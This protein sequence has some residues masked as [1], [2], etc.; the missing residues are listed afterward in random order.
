MLNMATVISPPF[1]RPPPG[2]AILRRGTPPRRPNRASS[3]PSRPCWLSSLTPRR[4]RRPAGTTSTCSSVQLRQGV[5][6]A[7][8][9]HRPRHL[10]APYV[11]DLLV[12][13]HLVQLRFLPARP[14]AVEVQQR[15][16]PHHRA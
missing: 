8:Q 9:A 12:G 4:R 1:G 6:P 7:T 16:Q 15:P 13:H 5:A 2:S 11:L 10:A 3:R 14:G